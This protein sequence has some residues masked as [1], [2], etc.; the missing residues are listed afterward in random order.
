[1]RIIA[2]V[3]VLGILSACADVP[4]ALDLA[5]DSACV[6]HAKQAAAQKEAGK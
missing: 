3:L 5:I 1:M 4:D 2:S 6:A